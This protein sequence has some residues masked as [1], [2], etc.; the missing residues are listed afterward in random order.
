MRVDSSVNLCLFLHNVASEIALQ[1]QSPDC[2]EDQDVQAVKPVCVGKL[3]DTNG[4]C[5]VENKKFEEEKNLRK[6]ST[7]F[8]ARRG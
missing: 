3:E 1:E 5:K 7:A 2:K 8:E 6:F 4:C